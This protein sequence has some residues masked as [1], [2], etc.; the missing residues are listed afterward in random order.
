MKRLGGAILGIL[1]LCFLGPII[2]LTG[3]LLTLQ[4]TQSPVSTAGDIF[5]TIATWA[6]SFSLVGAV[7]NALRWFDSGVM[8]FAYFATSTLVSFGLCYVVMLVERHIV[9]IAIVILVLVAVIVCAYFIKN[10]FAK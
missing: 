2:K 1:I 10:R 4:M 9:T 6:I 5:V 8:K 7:F 3:W